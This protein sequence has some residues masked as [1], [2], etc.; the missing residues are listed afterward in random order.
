MHNMS[1]YYMKYINCDKPQAQTGGTEKKNTK[2]RFN[3]RL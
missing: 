2:R 3:S 1:V